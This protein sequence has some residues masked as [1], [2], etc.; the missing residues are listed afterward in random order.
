MKVSLIIPA[1]NEQDLIEDTI[2]QIE[3]TLD[4]DYE[5][6]VVNDHSSDLTVKIVEDLAKKF[7]N[8]RLVHN[9]LD[10]CFGNALRVG[11]EK[12]QGE[13]VVPVMADL[14]DDV[15]TIKS[16][17]EKAKEGF[18]VVC[19]SRYMK[20]GKKIGGPLLKSLFSRFFGT[21]L[22][23]LVCMPTNDVANAFKMYNR[24]MLEGL[25]LRSSWFDISAEIPIKAYF[26]KYKITQVPTVWHDRK[27][28]QSKFDI[29][30][31]GG[32]YFK[33]YFWAIRNH[34]RNQFFNRRN[35]RL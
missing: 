27:K 3:K 23:L 30:K 16:M 10:G 22:N 11:F 21:T 31:V 7:S 35:Q 19:G 6:V 17:H 34:L 12:A 13:F 20:G 33:L 25:D 28:G 1:H 15:T 18:D 32:N 9:T 14:S 5:I 26:K 2:E 8:I 29:R 24:K 4:V